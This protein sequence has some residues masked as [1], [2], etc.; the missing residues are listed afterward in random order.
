M[1]YLCVGSLSERKNVVRLAAAFG[2]VGEG[3]LTFI[4]DG[5]LRA[6]L[7]GRPGVALVGS[8]PHDAI[9]DWLARSHVLCQP[10]LVE[11]PLALL[12]GMAAGRSV[13][14]TRAGG[15]SS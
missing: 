12:E 2:K 15:P 8:V 6:K 4:G 7:E 1:R 3:T 5:P 11:P 10:S 9:L 14:A 13:V